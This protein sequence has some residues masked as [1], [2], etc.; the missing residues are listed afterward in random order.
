LR[1]ARRGVHG[2]AALRRRAGAPLAADARARLR[3]DAYGRALRAYERDA[4]PYDGSALLVRA[5]LRH[6][7]ERIAPD[8][9]LGRLV[10]GG[11]HAC[12]VAGD[13]LGI[14]RAQAAQHTA[15]AIDELLHAARR[16]RDGRSAS[17][18]AS[19]TVGRADRW[20]SLMPAPVAS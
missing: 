13:H 12:D 18:A 5:S 6:P 8:G 11:L 19:R 4:R 20:S 15:R 9:G 14:L 2:G 17:A 10:R 7:G 16:R 3:H 1:W